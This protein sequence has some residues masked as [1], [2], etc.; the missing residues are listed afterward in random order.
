L[1]FALALAGAFSAGADFGVSAA[2]RENEARARS[3]DRVFMG[4]DNT[5]QGDD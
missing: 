5:S 2:K 1:A 4:W 3:K